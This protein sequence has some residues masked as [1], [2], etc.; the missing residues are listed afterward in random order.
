MSL[1]GARRAVR[2][3]N[4]PPGWVRYRV[5]ERGELAWPSRIPVLARRIGSGP[6]GKA[7][8]VLYVPE[9]YRTLN[10]ALTA[11]FHTTTW[12]SLS[13]LLALGWTVP[14]LLVLHT[15]GGLEA[16]V[17]ALPKASP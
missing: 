17:R 11:A 10:R 4:T 2:P 15:L 8:V 9:N 6:G 3:L 7:S 5:S 16:A 1:R 14:R 13:R 12:V